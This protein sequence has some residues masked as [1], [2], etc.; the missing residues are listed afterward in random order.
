[1]S[2]ASLTGIGAGALRLGAVKLPGSLIP[3]TT[4]GSIVVAGTFGSTTV[5]LEMDSLGGISESAPLIA[6]TLAGTAGG[7]ALLTAGNTIGALGSFTATGFTLDDAIPLT[8]TGAVA[9]GP[10]R[11]C[12]CGC[13]PLRSSLWTEAAAGCPTGCIRICCEDW[14]SSG[15]TRWRLSNTLDV[16]FCIEAVEEAPAG[17]GWPEIFNTDQGS[18]FTSPQFTGVL[19]AARVRISMDGRGRWMDNLCSLNDCGAA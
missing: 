1:M 2:L 5:S 6:G 13:S 11:R 12:V 3:T 16:E 18:Q 14:R 19:E 17:F 7:A 8:V 15:R 10:P 9:G 4:A